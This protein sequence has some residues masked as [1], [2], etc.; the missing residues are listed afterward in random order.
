[1]HT[2]LYATVQQFC[3]ILYIHVWSGQLEPVPKLLSPQLSSKRAVLSMSINR[4]LQISKVPLKSQVHGTSLFMSTAS[5][6]RIVREKIQWLRIASDWRDQ[7]Q[8]SSGSCIEWQ[9]HPQ[10]DIYWETYRSKEINW[11]NFMCEYA[12][13][14]THAWGHTCMRTYRYITHACLH[15]HYHLLRHIFRRGA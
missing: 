13:V 14:Q 4:N 10:T 6:Q 1:M 8:D 5:N 12:R 2:C 9:K 7:H 3:P 11:D 15:A